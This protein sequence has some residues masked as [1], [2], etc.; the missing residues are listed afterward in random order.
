[1]IPIVTAAL[2]TI[3]KRL[4]CRNQWTSRDDLDNSFTKNTEKSPEYL[5]RFAVTEAP[6]RNHHC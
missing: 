5:M 6:V 4:R 1:M 2:A 3:P